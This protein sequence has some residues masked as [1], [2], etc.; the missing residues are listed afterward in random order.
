ATPNG[1]VYVA[2]SG[3]GATF[4]GGPTDHVT[5]GDA[6]PDWPTELDGSPASRL[7]GA[8][9]FVSPNT[10]S[11]TFA[12]AYRYWKGLQPVAL[13]TVAR[14]GNGHSYVVTTAGVTDDTEPTWPTTAGGTVVDGSATWTE[15]ATK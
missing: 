15:V 4:E 2:V 6:E 14:P 12:L 9:S 13:G 3:T 1:C 10:S 5:F 7:V 11:S 8:S